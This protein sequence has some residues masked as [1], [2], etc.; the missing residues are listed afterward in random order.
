MSDEERAVA[1][2]PTK[3]TDEQ[4]SCLIP[5]CDRP[6]EAGGLCAAHRYRKRHD[7]PMSSPIRD[8]SR[9]AYERVIETFD[10][11]TKPEYDGEPGEHAWK[12]RLRAA[13]WDWLDPDGELRRISRARRKRRRLA[14]P[15][16]SKRLP[17]RAE[18]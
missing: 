8:G 10:A 3:W 5:G 17:R 14:K 7:L 11:I 15:Q 16:W 2:A 18:S 4:G 9:S 1:D 13:C 12:M 6:E